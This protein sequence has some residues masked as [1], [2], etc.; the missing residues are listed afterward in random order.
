MTTHRVIRFEQIQVI[1]M[2]KSNNKQKPITTK[3]EF[4]KQHQKQD[5]DLKIYLGTKRGQKPKT[6]RSFAI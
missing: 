3:K 4:I 2:P 6:G 5:D 1:T